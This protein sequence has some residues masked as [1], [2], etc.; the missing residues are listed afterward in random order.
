MFGGPHGGKHATVA[1]LPGVLVVCDGEAMDAQ[2]YFKIDELEYGYSTE[3][4]ITFPRT[5]DGRRMFM[6]IFT[7]QEEVPI[8][9]KWV[10][11][12]SSGY[13]LL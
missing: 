5:A 9:L 1:R 4:S 10:E 11:K 8:D 3:Y 6:E 13:R 7:A 12:E 2:C